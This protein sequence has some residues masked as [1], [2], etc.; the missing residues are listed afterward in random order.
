MSTTMTDSPQHR[1]YLAVPG[2][3]FCWGTV[4]GVI[5]STRHHVSRPFNGGLGFSGVIDFNI[6]WTDAQNCFE[7]G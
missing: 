2:N 3:Q 1:V 5:S 6:V 4:L 7:Q